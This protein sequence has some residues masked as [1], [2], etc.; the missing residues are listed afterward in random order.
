VVRALVA[1]LLADERLS[2]VIFADLREDKPYIQYV[3]T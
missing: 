3:L 2:R 1:R